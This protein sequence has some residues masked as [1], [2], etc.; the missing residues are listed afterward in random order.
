M[1][2]SAKIVVIYPRPRDEAAFEQ[3]YQVYKDVHLPMLESKLK[4]ISRLVATKVLSSPD[5]TPRTYRIAEIHF[6]DAEALNACIKSDGA[7]QVIDHA[8]SI[9]SGG[10]PIVMVCEEENFLYW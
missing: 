8:A 5:G 4:G 9:S 6:A 3:V 7:R 2:A 10:V 1:S